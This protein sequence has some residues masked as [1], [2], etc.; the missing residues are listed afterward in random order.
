MELLKTA[1]VTG[2]NKGIG[3][4]AARKL[5]ERNYNVILACRSLENAEKAKLELA[6]LGSAKGKIET[7]QLDVSSSESIKNFV[8]ERQ[9]LK[10]RID[11]LINN[12]GMAFKGDAFD[13][14]VNCWNILTK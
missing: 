8:A 13:D 3:F 7:A 12:A 1:V 9:A 6:A 14:N 2:A 11:V 5:L 4:Q 10:T